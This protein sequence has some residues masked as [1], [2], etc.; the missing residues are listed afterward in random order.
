M[1]NT[2]RVF[3]TLNFSLS[4]HDCIRHIFFHLVKTFLSIQTK[5]KNS[6]IKDLLGEPKRNQGVIMSKVLI[7]V[8]ILFGSS[9]KA[10]SP[11]DYWQPFYITNGQTLSEIFRSLVRNGLA[12]RSFDRFIEELKKKN[13]HIIDRNTIIAGSEILLP[14]PNSSLADNRDKQSPSVQDIKIALKQSGYSIALEPIIG[15]S[16]LDIEEK[17]DNAKTTL[18]SRR[19]YGVALHLIDR[20]TQNH[21]TRASL[22]IYQHKYDKADKAFESDKVRLHNLDFDKIWKK[23]YGL[24]YGVGLVYSESVYLS[25]LDSTRLVMDPV[26]QPGFNLILGYNQLISKVRL[27]FETKVTYLFS[28]HAST[29]RVRHGTKYMA[30]FLTEW[31]HDQKYISL[32]RFWFTFKNLDSSISSQQTKDIGIGLGIKFQ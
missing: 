12:A 15:Y 8:A 32:L 17:D 4:Y 20:H 11:Y 30:G 28:S 29:F 26:F 25:A 9:L 3:Y 23:D 13:P 18:L 6:F 10:S 21:F 14:V 16:R 5:V 19:N 7:L 1:T 31:I 27:T 2:H 24:I 22:R